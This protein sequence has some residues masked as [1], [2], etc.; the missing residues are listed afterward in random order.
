MSSVGRLAVLSLLGTSQNHRKVEVVNLFQV[1]RART[2]QHSAEL[3]PR[4]NHSDC[5]SRNPDDGSTDG[6]GAWKPLPVTLVGTGNSQGEK[7][8]SVCKHK[9]TIP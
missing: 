8:G 1:G 7:S 2:T 3:S 4:E 6:A 5:C 9:R